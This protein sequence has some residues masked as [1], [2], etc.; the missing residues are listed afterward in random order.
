VALNSHIGG[1][2]AF[3]TALWGALLGYACWR[4]GALWLPIGLHY[5]WNL[6]LV[7]TGQALSGTIME[8]AAVRMVWTAGEWWSGGGY[9]PEG[10][11]PTSVLA[12][13]VFAVLRRGR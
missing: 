1:L 9:G 12:L 2:G 3:N 7:L 10:G 5:G 8:A 11:L 4:T 6:G 13:V